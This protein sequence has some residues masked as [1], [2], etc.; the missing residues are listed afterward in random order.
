MKNAYRIFR[1]N[2]RYYY[3]EDNKSGIQKSLG[4]DDIREARRLLNA[5]ND[6][7]PLIGNDH[8]DWNWLTLHGTIHYPQPG[9]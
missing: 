4:T 7:R 3:W 8:Q 6:T 1:R 2:K 9:Y 5:A